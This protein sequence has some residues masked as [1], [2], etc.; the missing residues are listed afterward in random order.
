MGWLMRSGG[1]VLDPLAVLAGQALVLASLTLGACA[2]RPGVPGTRPE[3]ASEPSGEGASA[4]ESPTVPETAASTEPDPQEPCAPVAPS[5][6][7]E[8]SL[9]EYAAERVAQ[10]STRL[11]RPLCVELAGPMRE[12][13]GPDER[14]IADVLVRDERSGQA[15]AFRLAAQQIG[16]GGRWEEA[17]FERRVLEDFAL[18]A[19]PAWLAS[20]PALTMIWREEVQSETWLTALTVG[21]EATICHQRRRG[22]TCW[23][24]PGQ[25]A[26]VRAWDFG[27][28]EP[29]DLEESPSGLL[30]LAG[31]DGA[32]TR[33]GFR[34]AGQTQR[35]ERAAVTT[36]P[37][38]A[39]RI[40]RVPAW[41][42]RARP[43]APTA[44]QAGAPEPYHR[45][46]TA[47]AS[48]ELGPFAFLPVAPVGDAP[49]L[50]TR[51]MLSA[52]VCARLGGAW[53]CTAPSATEDGGQRYDE[54]RVIDAVVLGP[55]S[56]AIVR[57][58][59]EIQRGPE[60][61][62]LLTL[63]ILDVVDGILVRRGSLPI[64]T[65][66]WVTETTSD[67]T[68]HRMTR[69][70][71]HRVRAESEGCV[72]IEEPDNFVGLVGVD[73]APLEQGLPLNLTRAGAELPF[74]PDAPPGV[75]RSV[76]DLAGFWQVTAN[77][78]TRVSA[79]AN[80][81]SVRLVAPALPS[82]M[83]EAP[84][85]CLEDLAAELEVRGPLPRIEA[86]TPG[87][88]HPCG[89]VL[90]GFQDGPNRVRLVHEGERLVRSI[91]TYVLGSSTYRSVY[92]ELYRGSAHVGQTHVTTQYE[93]GAV[94]C[95]N[96][97]RAT[98]TL[99]ARG[100]PTSARALVE[101]CEG[102]DSGV[103]L[104][105]YVW[106]RREGHDE[107]Q[108][109][110]RH[111]SD[112]RGSRSLE[113][114]VPSRTAPEAMVT[115]EDGE[116]GGSCWLDVRDERGLLRERLFGGEQRWQYAYSCEGAD[117]PALEVP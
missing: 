63:E 8:A 68:T 51:T 70:L 66:S 106:A 104:T 27:Y 26:R 49:V 110:R 28:A 82:T 107:A 79:C 95:V 5:D 67:G 116:T 1:R 90:S 9:L 40:E 59:R 39:T 22:Q 108:V 97:R 29:L 52:R 53:T 71:V 84:R 111:A 112:A 99:D 77:G 96:T 86:S 25:P 78:L 33:S 24:E 30:E 61:L 6:P 2:G 109:T 37:R 88:N 32:I 43:V 114:Y 69:R 10:A 85:A 117:W 57:S 7:R 21:R 13:A 56:V 58:T 44:S 103:F 81:P 4:T 46:V 89:A 50:L 93:D 75:V 60:G 65:A 62:A 54:N 98:Y 105:R 16:R 83:S 102:V 64:G 3:T 72:R 38:H 101:T 23:A 73:F 115:I 36:T 55:R 91:E 12:M 14:V 18:L 80:G 15:L 41:A 94:E 92:E 48:V 35:F 19:V 100:R 20:R 76:E 45:P 34:A 87:S 47:R 74:T 42:P 31:A 11:G 113:T 17:F